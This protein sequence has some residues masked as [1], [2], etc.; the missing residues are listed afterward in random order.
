MYVVSVTF[1]EAFH[2]QQ[3]TVTGDSSG[4][5]PL[6][7]AYTL[8]WR[9]ENE[10]SM[11]HV[12]NVCMYNVHV[13][14]HVVH[15]VLH[16]TVLLCVCVIKARLCFIMRSLNIIIIVGMLLLGVCVLTTYYLYL[17]IISLKMDVKSI[18]LSVA[19]LLCMYK[20]QSSTSA[21]AAPGTQITYNNLCSMYNADRSH[22][23]NPIP[24]SLSHHRYIPIY[25][26]ICNVA[27]YV[28]RNTQVIG[29]VKCV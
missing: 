14:V 3:Q 19:I 27:I 15:S 22:S 1:Q 9:V 28:L 12:C 5:Q 16:C 13:L 17:C 2:A 8:L 21:A 29:Q 10:L 23:H 11:L 26:Y 25:M 20:K 6:A 18:S 4:L 24:M 7:Q